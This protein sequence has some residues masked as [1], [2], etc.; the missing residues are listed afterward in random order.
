MTRYVAF[1]RAI[2]VGGHVVRMEALRRLFESMGAL[3][4]ATFIASG[5][6]IFDTRRTNAAAL[7]RSIEAELQKALG[8]PV[9][10]F[11][12]T[13]PEVSATAAHTPFPE[14]EFAAGATMYVGFL[15]DKPAKERLRAVR[16]LRTAV[17]E[18]AVRER[19][20]YWLRRKAPWVKGYAGPPFEKT[21]ATGITMRN[22]STVRKLAA[23]YAQPP[24]SLE[25]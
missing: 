15:K 12:R 7:E 10:T 11:L 18:F 21:L 24:G 17:D 6:V 14:S 4:V 25:M 13:I 1:L 3:N 9:A 20:L 2:N 8:F 19:E 16:A 5:N 23:K 22:V